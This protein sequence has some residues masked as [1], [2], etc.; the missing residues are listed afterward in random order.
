MI[1][2]IP[3]INSII[4]YST[5][6]YESDLFQYLK[7]FVVK[8]SKIRMRALDLTTLKKN[9]F[10][11]QKFKGFFNHINT[12]FVTICCSENHIRDT[13]RWKSIKFSFKKIALVL[14][15]KP[16]EFKIIIYYRY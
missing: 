15:L 9:S 11:R 4:N 16:L 14:S 3:F 7:V 10:S 5:F 2:T 6:L 13:L 12:N 1:Q 8:I